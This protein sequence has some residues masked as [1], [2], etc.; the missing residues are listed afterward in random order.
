MALAMAG[1]I[2]DLRET[3]SGGNTEV[4][5]SVI[6]HFATEARPFQ[7]QTVPSLEREFSVPRQFTEYVMPRLPHRSAKETVALGSYWTGSMGEGVLI[8]LDGAA[9]MYV[10]ASDM[11]DLLGGLSNFDLEHSSIRLN[12]PFETIS[13][14]DGTPREDFVADLALNSSDRDELGS[15]PAMEAAV[16]YFRST[17]KAQ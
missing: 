13:H 3:P 1:L 10:I 8:G 4:G 14:I 2:L 11:G 9:D 5:R 16:S 17:Q 12:L 15:D 7:V 6:G